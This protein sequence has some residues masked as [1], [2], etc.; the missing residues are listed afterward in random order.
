MFG[1]GRL[2]CVEPSTGQ[3]PLMQRASAMDWP[4]RC[5]RD[6]R[7]QHGHTPDGSRRKATLS[8]DAGEKL[9][10]IEAWSS[11]EMDF[12]LHDFGVSEDG[13]ST[14]IRFTTFE[15]LMAAIDGCYGQFMR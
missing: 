2:D 6:S 1:T 15:D 4:K 13:N 10:L 8:L 11:G 12:T 3:Q 5:W 9:A 14:H 7:L